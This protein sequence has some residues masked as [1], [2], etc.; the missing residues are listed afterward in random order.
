MHLD[1]ASTQNSKIRLPYTNFLTFDIIQIFSV[2]VQECT[3]FE[4][5]IVVIGTQEPPCVQMEIFLE[6]F[7]DFNDL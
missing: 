7:V 3:T 6:I 5:S 1:H 2:I 4:L